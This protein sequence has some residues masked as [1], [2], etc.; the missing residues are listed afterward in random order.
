MLRKTKLKINN[1]CRTCPRTDNFLGISVNGFSETHEEPIYLMLVYCTQ[2]QFSPNDALP[3]RVCPDCLATLDTAYGFWKQCRQREAQLRRAIS[4]GT[5]TSFPE[6]LSEP[7]DQPVPEAPPV[8]EVAPAET[9][10][11]TPQSFWCCFRKCPTVTTSLADMEQHAQ[12]DHFADRVANEVQRAPNREHVCSVCCAGYASLGSLEYHRMIQLGIRSKFGV[13]AGETTEKQQD[14]EKEEETKQQ[15]SA[16]DFEVSD[17]ADELATNS[18]MPFEIVP[19]KEESYISD[20]QDES[21]QDAL[22]CEAEKFDCPHCGVETLSDEEKQRHLVCECPILHHQEGS[23]KVQ[24]LS[25]QC[26]RC[27]RPFNTSEGLERHI[28]LCTADKPDAK[29]TCPNCGSVFN[30]KANLSRHLKIGACLRDPY[31]CKYCF[32]KLPDMKSLNRHCKVECRAMLNTEPNGIKMKCHCEHCGKGFR[33][34]ALLR[35][36]Q[37]V[38]GCG[39]EDR[40]AKTV[41]DPKKIQCPYCFEHFILKNLKRHLQQ[42]CL[43]LLEKQVEAKRAAAALAQDATSGTR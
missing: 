22:K 21:V 6:E 5:R 39:A 14:G 34:K 27:R 18:T 35:R 4:G 29:L 13:S 3:Q 23:S 26:P 15:E 43:V 16:M 37:I 17:A 42:H 41:K 8:P 24:S 25:K 7:E 36:H 32:E 10:A 28:S 9:A 33:T 31:Q 19:I 30:A 1:K 12:Q 11:P 2:M 20:E 38:D 40:M